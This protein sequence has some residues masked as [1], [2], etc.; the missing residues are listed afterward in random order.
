MKTRTLLAISLIALL[1]PLIA[2]AQ[3]TKAVADYFPLRVGD[4]WTYRNEGGAGEYTLKVV[5]EES[6]PGQATRFLVELSAGVKVE[7]TYSKV[8]GWVLLHAVRYPEHEGLQTK[9]EPPRQYLPNPLV[10]G[11]T[12]EWSGKDQ[13]QNDRQEANR[14]AGFEEVTVAAGKF[15]AMKIVS[16]ITG[17][18]VPMTKTYWYAAG[19]GM[20]KTTT[21][22]GETKYGSELI[23]YSFRKKPPK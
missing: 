20:V 4:S 3:K 19:V 8:D 11:V 21:D 14:I 17:A 18:A 10:A 15:R 1:P 7:N 12:W 16:K 2:S 13:S 23:D 6:Q 5:S 9:Y 22:A